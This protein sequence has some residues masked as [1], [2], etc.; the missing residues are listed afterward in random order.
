MAELVAMP[1][2]EAYKDSGV[3]W[4]GDIPESWDISKIKNYSNIYNGDSLNEKQK[5]RYSSEDENH[6]AYISSKDINVQN[7]QV[8]YLNG[9]RIPRWSSYK[10]CPT[11]STLM[12]I[13]GGSAGKK[14]AFTNQNVCFVNKLA[15]FV[16]KK[17]IDN[18]Y[19]FFYLSSKTYKDQFFNAM[20]G[21]IGGVAISS[22]KNFRLVLPPVTVQVAIANFLDK[23]TAQ[24]DEAITIKE[25]QIELLKERKQIIIQQAVTKGISYEGRPNA[26]MKDSGVDWIGEIPEHWEIFANRVLFT[27][28]VEPGRDEL[29]LLSVSIHSGVSSEEISEEDNVRGRVKIEDKSKY[30]AVEPND[31]VFNMMRAW[32]GAIGAVEVFGMV[33]PAY[34]IAAPKKK[35]SGKFFEYQYRCPEFIQQMDRYSK[36]ITDFRKRLY[37]DGFKQLSTIYPPYEEQLKIVEF[38]YDLSVQNESAIVLQKQQIEKLKE[39]KTS[40]I[41]SAVTGKIKVPEVDSGC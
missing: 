17:G 20:T 30:N 10:V 38:I 3:E 25:K 36:G 28:R 9:L 5:A 2:Y 32:Q 4:L 11:S 6:L 39:Y 1:I 29:P 19:L 21:L 41:N 24:I 27:E 13:E 14:I 26:P 34:V 18:K 23:K 37:W 33:S 35:L 40:L 31:I 15:C 8:N 16:A 7:A 12:C 22:I